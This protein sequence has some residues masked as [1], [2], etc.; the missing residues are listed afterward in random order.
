MARSEP[1]KT[2]AH[3][4]PPGLAIPALRL[5]AG[6]GVLLHLGALTT[7]RTRGFARMEV[8]PGR[9][10]HEAVWPTVWSGEGGSG[11]QGLKSPGGDDQGGPPAGALSPQGASMDPSIEGF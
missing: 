9:G 3:E 11:T 7:D 4:P 2:R 6:A 5:G 8:P 10:A 1:L